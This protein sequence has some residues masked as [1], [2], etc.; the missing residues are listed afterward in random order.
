MYNAATRAYASVAESKKEARDE[1]EVVD[2]WSV[3]MGDGLIS[4]PLSKESIRRGRETA[5]N[6]D[7]D[8]SSKFI[9]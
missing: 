4:D 2:D 7:K 3:D 6:D 1:W 9:I 8:N 5:P